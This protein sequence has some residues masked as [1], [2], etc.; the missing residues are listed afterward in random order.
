MVQAGCV[1]LIVVDRATQGLCVLARR[2]LA[3][4]LALLC[5][6]GLLLAGPTA[7][8]ADE[9]GQLM[10]VLDASGSM[11]EPAAGGGTRIDAARAALATVIDR[12]PEDAPV[13][14]RVFGSGSSADPCTDSQRVVDVG[15]GNRPQLRAAV[16]AYSPYGETPISYALEQ[17]GKDLRPDGKRSIL[18]VSDGEPTCPPDPC[19][20][21]ASLAQQGIDL[22]IDVVGLD[23]SGKAADILRCIAREGRGSYYDVRSAEELIDALATLA[24]RAARPYQGTGTPVMGGSSPADA[25]AIGPGSYVDTIG[26]RKSATGERHYRVHR[27]QPGS[28]ITTT[29]TILAP[30]Y[31]QRQTGGRYAPD[32]IFV[33]MKT[34]DGRVGCGLNSTLEFNF[35]GSIAAATASSAGG[36][37]DMQ[38]AAAEAF[39][40]K[41]T[42]LGDN[43]FSTPLE[44][45]VFEEP[46]ATGTTALPAPVSGRPSWVE[47]PQGEPRDLVAGGASFASAVPLNPGSYRVAIVPNE[48]QLFRVEVGWGQQLTALIDVPAPTGKLAEEIRSSTTIFT[49]LYSPTR[50]PA[51]SRLNQADGAPN[52]LDHAAGGARVS[53]TT[54]VVHY[55]NRE[56]E[57]ADRGEHNFLAG[58]YYIAVTLS[59]ANRGGDEPS[60]E[61][62]FLLHV[63][64]SGQVSGAPTYLTGPSAT[65]G[66]GSPSRPPATASGQLASAEPSAVAAD[67]QRTPGGMAPLSAVLI[68]AGALG[69]AALLAG[70]VLYLVQ[71]RRRAA[72]GS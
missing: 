30:A 1:M 51:S 15:T 38:C 65:P 21:A 26:H 59:D 72:G 24:T 17:A 70:A 6:V 2:A 47:P 54:G 63:G 33:E 29:A 58:S 44:I 13:G 5:L 10:L 55:R 52:G 9:R 4:L 56:L 23:V 71:R 43:E 61:L 64:V 18:L 16:E 32:G 46:G 3:G 8:R 69:V 50:A 41:V 57:H 12:L 60:Y 27:S 67:P 53:A 14:M 7:A 37:N 39:D 48:V 35:A 11:A 68:G 28:T 25:P 66:A 19:E 22:H 31:V 36:I 62:P 42:R 45:T 34:S 49:T 20:I 40:V